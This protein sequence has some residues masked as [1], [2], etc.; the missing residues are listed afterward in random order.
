MTK[1]EAEIHGYKVI[2]ASAFEVGLIKGERGIRTWFCQDFDRKL[3]PLDHPEIL[4]AI[5]IN[6]EMERW[7]DA[8]YIE[9]VGPL[10]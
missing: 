7:S 3:P 4:R 1:K 6:E 8:I 10:K 2:A 5:E 9:S